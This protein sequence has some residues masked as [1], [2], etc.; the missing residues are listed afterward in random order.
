MKVSG[1][2]FIRNALK[3]DYP[4]KE[5]I[6]SILPIV[7]EMIVAVGKSDDETRI[8]IDSLGDKIKIIKTNK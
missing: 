8:L 6:L 3:L 7:D 4:V 2:T 1:F 5:A